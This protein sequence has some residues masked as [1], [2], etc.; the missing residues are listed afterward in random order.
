[1]KRIQPT[2][3]V[4]SRES[5][6]SG[7]NVQTDR[8]KRNTFSYLNNFPKLQSIVFYGCVLIVVTIG[9][10]Y[11]V[12][13]V[14]TKEWSHMAGTYL[15]FN[16][17]RLGSAATASIHHYA[18]WVTDALQGTNETTS[19][20]L[21]PLVKEPLPALVSGYSTGLVTHATKFDFI[22][23]PPTERS[24][25]PGGGGIVFIAHACKRQPFEWFDKTADCSACDPMPI[26]VSIT[27]AL[28]KNGFAVMAMA[29]VENFAKCWHQNDRVQ[30]GL[31]MQYIVEATRGFYESHHMNGAA[32]G[33]GVAAS[34]QPA[35]Y[36]I[37]VENGGVFLG[38]L[39]W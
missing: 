11:I 22:W 26:Q 23:Q 7:L 30:V 3:R 39:I 20:Q 36:A 34:V 4:R 31:A 10:S 32:S 24:E 16:H 18:H 29:P 37:G 27:N 25:R 28:R 15:P 19:S 13:P 9:L 35:M 5:L 17:T 1:M 12:D 38:T 33:N 21:H 8:E 14:A 2:I 6:N